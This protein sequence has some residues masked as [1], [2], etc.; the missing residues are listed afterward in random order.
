MKQPI[1]CGDPSEANCDVVSAIGGN[2]QSVAVELLAKASS[3]EVYKTYGP[4][5]VNKSHLLTFGR[6]LDL[7]NFLGIIVFCF[8]KE[9]QLP[10]FPCTVLLISIILGQSASIERI[11]SFFKS[12]SACIVLFS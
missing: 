8:C 11:A 9:D 12:V 2:I 10:M 4:V 1:S 5:L 3:R 6:N 7:E